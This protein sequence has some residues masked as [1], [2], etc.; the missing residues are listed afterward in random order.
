MSEIKTSEVL[1]ILDK[2]EMFQ[3]QRAGRELWVDKPTEVQEQ[4][5]T[6][7]NRDIA[8]IRKYIE[9]QNKVF[10]RI[11]KRLGQK[12]ELEVVAG[13]KGSLEDARLDGYVKGIKKAIE[14]V[15]KEGGIE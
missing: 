8:K 1:E 13:E 3:G 9:S 10:E 4:D 7:F 12:E 11:L 6:N 2:I 15:K 5:L 14:V